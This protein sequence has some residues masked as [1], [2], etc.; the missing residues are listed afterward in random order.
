M[1]EVANNNILEVDIVLKLTFQEVV[2]FLVIKKQKTDLEY[3]MNAKP[4]M[5]KK[6]TK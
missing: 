5:E 6:I 2:D 1:L 3:Y 4:I